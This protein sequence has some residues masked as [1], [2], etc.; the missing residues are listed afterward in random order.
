MD[1]KKHYVP[2]KSDPEIFKKLMHELGVSRSVRFVVDVWSLEDE[3]LA[4]IPPPVLV[5][6]LH[7]EG[8]TKAKPNEDGVV[9]LKQTINNACGL[10]AILHAVCNLPALI[11][12]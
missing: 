1:Y 7:V 3:M 10:Y 9:W 12:R 5:L 11:G 4:R 2:L 8:G 6:I